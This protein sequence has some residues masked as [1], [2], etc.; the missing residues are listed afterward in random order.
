MIFVTVGTNELSFNRLLRAVD[1]IAE[2]GREKFI[3]QKGF[4]SYEPAYAE[5]FTFR[6]RAEMLELIFRAEIVIAHGGFGI[7]GDCIRANKR[8][9]IVPREEKY[10]EA[11]NPQWE[12]AEYLAR[13]HESIMCVRR[14]G[15]LD[16]AIE[17]AIRRLRRLTKAPRYEYNCYVPE[18]L[19]NFVAKLSDGR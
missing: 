12:L 6:D 1:E 11:V 3:I 19:A 4:S 17:R 5:W 18:L 14:N 9:I 15:G 7:L 16:Q 2:K 13:R 8:I 10:G